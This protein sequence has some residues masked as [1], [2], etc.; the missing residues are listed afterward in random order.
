MYIENTAN[1]LAGNK[2]A[3]RVDIVK[4]KMVKESSLLYPQRDVKSPGPN[5][6]KGAEGEDI[7]YSATE[8]YSGKASQPTTSRGTS[9]TTLILNQYKG[10]LD[11]RE[12]F[13]LAS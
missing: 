3:K 10:T 13:L 7:V 6:T 2:Q 4:L 1:M 9:V 8:R 11:S 12:P 5:R